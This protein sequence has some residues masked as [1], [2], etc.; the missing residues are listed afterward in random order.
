MPPQSASIDR[1]PDWARELLA[2]AP[3]ARLGLL[4]ADDR[5][6]VLPVTFA[7]AG[8]ELWT[9]VDHKPKRTEGAEL[10]RVRWLRRNPAAAL[11]VDRY[12]DHWDRLAWVQALGTV[13]VLD[14]P[15]AEALAALQ[16]KYE[17]YRARPPGGPYL[18]LAPR[19]LLT[20]AADA[21]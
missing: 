1:L 18:R 2:T 9:A 6:R 13:D 3:V 11:T 14:E 15:A 7:V 21:L 16:A 19:R 17:P 4:D 10:A 5:P 12:S 8:G 20:W